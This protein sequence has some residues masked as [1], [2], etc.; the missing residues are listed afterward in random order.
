MFS[1]LVF[2]FTGSI[3]LIRASRLEK[4]PNFFYEHT[5]LTGTSECYPI[6]GYSPLIEM[7]EE[8]ILSSTFSRKIVRVPKLFLP[9]TG[10][11][12][13]GSVPHGPLDDYILFKETLLHGE[14]RVRAHV[15]RQNPPTVGPNG[16]SKFRITKTIAASN[17]V[18]YATDPPMWSKVN[19]KA[20]WHSLI[21]L[22]LFSYI[23]A[24]FL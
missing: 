6:Q 7:W 9:Y 21:A 3:C 17:S 2:L 18:S 10:R 5:Y 4:E 23:N 15:G 19:S 22:S 14:R 8:L 24:R 16:R 1:L 12:V 20:K 11:K 13:G